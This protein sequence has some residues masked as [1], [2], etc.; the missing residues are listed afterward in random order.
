MQS[1][2][3]LVK[4]VN[5]MLGNGM[6]VQAKNVAFGGPHISQRDAMNAA[7]TKAYTNA[8]GAVPKAPAAPYVIPKIQVR[9]GK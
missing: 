4:K 7:M 6:S 2:L 3:L 1:F 5:N 9:I 8:Y